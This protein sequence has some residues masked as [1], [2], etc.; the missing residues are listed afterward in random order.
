MDRDSDV[1]GM[2]N[3]I[4]GR[5]KDIVKNIYRV[6]MEVHKTGVRIQTTSSVIEFDGKEM[7]RDRTRGLQNYTRYIES[8]VPDK[9]SFI[10]SELVSVITN[11]MT[12]MD[13]KLFTKCLEWMSDNF[14]GTHTGKIE[15]LLNE[16]L[17]HSFSYLSGH[18]TLVRNTHDLPGILSSLRGTYTSSRSSDV[19]LLSLREKTESIAKLATGNKNANTLAALRTGI[20]LYICLRTYTMQYYTQ[21]RTEGVLTHFGK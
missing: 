2:V 15:E 3:D 10:R 19:I 14:R 1:V 7:L 12:S 8:V 20:L 11:M 16:C 6:F 18:T 17:V 13:P 9:A 21:A 5:L 4:Q